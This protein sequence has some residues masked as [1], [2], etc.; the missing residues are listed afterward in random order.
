MINYHISNEVFIGFCKCL[1][2]IAIY[3]YNFLKKYRK[4]SCIYNLV[5][6]YYFGVWAKFVQII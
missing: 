1:F 2:D 6:I 4:K 5:M 3:I